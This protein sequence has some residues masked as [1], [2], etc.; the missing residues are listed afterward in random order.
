[1][2]L[3]LAFGTLLFIVAFVAAILRIDEE[4]SGIRGFF[5]FLISI[6]VVGVVIILA[7]LLAITFSTI[8]YTEEF[9]LKRS[10]WSK[11]RRD[12]E[13][14]I[15]LANEDFGDLDDDCPA[16]SE[17]H[18]LY[19]SYT[20]L[21]PERSG[22]G[23]DNRKLSRQYLNGE[24][25][26]LSQTLEGMTTSSVSI[27]KYPS[28]CR[29][30]RSAKRYSSVRNQ[31]KIRGERFIAQFSFSMEGLSIEGPDGVPTGVSEY[32]QAMLIY[33]VRRIYEEQGHRV[34]RCWVAPRGSID[35]R[36]FFRLV[37][38]LM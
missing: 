33:R 14:W 36:E 29:L 19:E 18:E 34:V 10:G 1:M 9:R 27:L 25:S 31:D 6:P 35:R 22:S 8:H 13:R 15:L 26:D 11:Y 7:T 20:Q 17:L 30:M 38:R 32:E 16:A 3:V 2:L 4:D 21:T 5:E 37:V 28:D 12:I 23:E 24:L